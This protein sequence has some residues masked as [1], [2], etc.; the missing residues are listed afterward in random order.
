[1][2]E[3]HIFRTNPSLWW[4]PQCKPQVPMH[5]MIAKKGPFIGP[6]FPQIVKKKFGIPYQ[7]VEG[8]H[9][10]PL[11]RPEETVALIKT[12]IQENV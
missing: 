10:F 7:I 12:L 2:D 11:E 5:L 1:M 3:V 8:S 4:L 9:M 6:G